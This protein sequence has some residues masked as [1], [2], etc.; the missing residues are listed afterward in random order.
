MQSSEHYRLPAIFDKA[1]EA[2]QANLKELQYSFS[3]NGLRGQGAEEI[4]KTFLREHLPISMGIASGCAVDSKGQTSKQLDIII[5]DSLNSMLLYTDSS[6]TNL[7][8]PIENVISVIEVKS[9]LRERDIENAINNMTSVKEMSKT[10]YIL[11]ET[12]FP[13][14]VLIQ[15]TVNLYGS[16]YCAMPTTYSLF[17]F[18]SEMSTENIL[19]HI[20]EKQSTKPIDKRIDN[21]CVLSQCN[22]INQS[23]SGKLNALPEPGSRTVAASTKQSLLL[24]YILNFNIWC[25]AKFPPLQLSN[26]LGNSFHFS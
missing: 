12:P 21:L 17:A 13:G 1:A 9:N 10:A 19:R 23:Q 6:N 24:W 20:N 15:D 25:Q 16:T 26:Y 14:Q 18:S 8:I 22:V 5:Y 2:M 11:G 4:L 7:L 3:H